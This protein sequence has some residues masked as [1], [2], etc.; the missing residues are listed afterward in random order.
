HAAW[1]RLVLPDRVGG[2]ADQCRSCVLAL[3][4]APG[5]VG[6]GRG[7]RLDGRAVELRHVHPVRV[8]CAVTQSRTALFLIVILILVRA[9][10]AG[11]LPLSADE[12]YYWLWSKYPA[13]GYYDH[14]PAIAFVIRFGT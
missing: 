8:A 1:L 9:A 12:A 7:R 13:A 10:M 2:R 14:P 5:L 4:P 11:L 6:G 3:L